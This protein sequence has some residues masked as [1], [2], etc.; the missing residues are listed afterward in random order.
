MATKITRDI[1]E[2]FLN[3]KLKGHLKLAGESG[4]KA[5]YEAMTAAA[6]QASREQAIAKLI[7]RFSV[8]DA[9]REIAV[10]V[11]TLKRA[12]P[13]LVNAR[14]EDEGLS[15]CLD[16]L[17]RVGGPSRI[18]GHHYIPVLHNHGDKVGRQQRVMLAVFGLALARV[19]GVRP[20]TGLNR[21]PYRRC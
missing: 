17:K 1:I 5:D 3:C 11:T 16:G 12:A 9:C 8:G 7:A 19:Q 10:S 15:L 20:A 13:L 2:S 6:R 14:I 18:G 21:R 4:T